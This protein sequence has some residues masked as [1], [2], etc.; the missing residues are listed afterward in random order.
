MG[1]PPS[2]MVFVQLNESLPFSAKQVAA[3]LREQGVKVGVVSDRMFR[4]VLHYWVDDSG[5]E[6]TLKAFRSML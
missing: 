6:Q 4:M 5:I 1:M 3:Q 2:N